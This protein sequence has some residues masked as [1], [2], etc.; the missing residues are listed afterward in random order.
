VRGFWEAYQNTFREARTEF[1]E[2]TSGE[3]AGGLFWTTRGVDPR[4]E[5]IEYDGATLLVFDDEGKITLFRG[6]Y[7]TR[8]LTRTVG[9]RDR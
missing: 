3:R 6:Y 8:E 7:D 4:G 2:L 1:F 9:Q 5:P